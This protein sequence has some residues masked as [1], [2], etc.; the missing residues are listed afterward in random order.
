MPFIYH[1]ENPNSIIY[2]SILKVLRLFGIKTEA[3]K[4]DRFINERSYFL[5]SDDLIN[6]SDFSLTETKNRIERFAITMRSHF[7]VTNRFLYYSCNSSYSN[8]EIEKFEYFGVTLVNNII[9]L[10]EACGMNPA[11]LQE[12]EVGHLLEPA[13]K[14]RVRFILHEMNYS[15]NVSILKNAIDCIQDLK[16]SNLIHINSDSIDQ[17]DAD[18][19][20]KILKNYL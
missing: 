20:Q 7:P 17:I 19:I 5:V 11:P 6:P 16:R 2:L 12:W 8:K 9:E 10:F 1:H 15:K 3:L 18:E 4:P 14:G 13:L